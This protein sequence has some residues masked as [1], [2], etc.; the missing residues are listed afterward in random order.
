MD[1]LQFYSREKKESEN[2]RGP[3]L[4]RLFAY[5]FACRQDE[6]LFVTVIAQG[7]EK[8]LKAI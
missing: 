6:P 4:D 5:L 2:F 7:N 8:H 3:V 1:L